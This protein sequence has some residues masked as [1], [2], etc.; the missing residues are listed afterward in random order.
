MSNFLG[1]LNRG[2]VAEIA[3]GNEVWNQPAYAYSS[4]ILGESTDIPAGAAPGTTK[5]V[6]ISTA[7]RYVPEIGAHWDN[8][9]VLTD[10]E[11]DPAFNIEYNLELDANGT[12]IGGDWLTENRPDFLWVQSTPRWVG[13]YA[14][15]HDIYKASLN[16][17]FLE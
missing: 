3:R 5:V 12:I 10:I 8:P 11:D 15:I 17:E 16:H 6:S 2:F 1:L 9:A 13:Y 4:K 7:L 14:G